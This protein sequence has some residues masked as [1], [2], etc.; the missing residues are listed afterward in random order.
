MGRVTGHLVGWAARRGDVETARRL[1]E[2]AR[3]Q[4]VANGEASEAL[5]TE[6]WMAEAAVFAGDA[7]TALQHVSELL[8][9][10]PKLDAG[11]RILPLLHR[12]RGWA[13]LAL[14]VVDDAA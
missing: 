10:A 7:G 13:F 14:G 5:W 9:R 6:A 4:Q 8:A 11:G 12:I 1:L 2:S 3:D